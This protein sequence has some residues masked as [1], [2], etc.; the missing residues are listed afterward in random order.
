MHNVE[1]KKYIFNSVVGLLPKNVA[2]PC[3]RF[4]TTTDLQAVEKTATMFS[5]VIFF[6]APTGMAGVNKDKF[7]N[8]NKSHFDFSKINL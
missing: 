1:E 7:K 6:A 3:K 5:R 4:F 8:I 2:S